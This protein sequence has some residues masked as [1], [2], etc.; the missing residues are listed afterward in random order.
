VDVYDR[1]EL[2]METLA[3][4][5]VAGVALAMLWLRRRSA[6]R[7]RQLAARGILV[8]A[9]LLRRF[10]RRKP[11][12]GQRHYVEFEFVTADGETR[13]G[14]VQVSAQEYLD[15]AGK[16]RIVIVYDPLAPDFQR[17]AAYLER[18]G[19]VVASDAG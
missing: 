6:D 7:L 11:K 1:Q 12:A 14:H 17:T 8:E 5:F 19:I 3:L 18:K 13:S 4:L 15:I 2:T 10:T 16:D 9:R